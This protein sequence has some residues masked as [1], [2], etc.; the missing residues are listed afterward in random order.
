MP[1]W[2]CICG[3]EFSGIT[4]PDKCPKC[5]VDKFKLDELHQVE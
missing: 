5:G 2:T 1:K 3:F 4:F